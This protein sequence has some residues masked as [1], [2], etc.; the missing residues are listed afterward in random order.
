MPL[1][2]GVRF[3]RAGRV[4]YFDPANIELEVDDWV[5]VDTSRGK[6][7][8]RVVLAPKQVEEAELSEP[9]KPVLRKADASDFSKVQC[10]KEKIEAALDKCQERI[11]QHS[12]PMKLVGAE[13]SF[14]GSRLTFFFTSEGRVD[15]RDLVRDLASMFKT[16]IE[17]RQIGARDEARMIGGLGRCGRPLCCASFLT[18]FTNVSIKMA[19]EQDLPLNPQKISG[20]CGRLLCCLSYEEKQYCEIRAT[21]PRLDE[22]VT[23]SNGPGRVTAVNVVKESVMVEVESGSSVEVP[24]SQLAPRE[25]QEGAPTPARTR[26]RRP[27]KKKAAATTETPSSS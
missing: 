15:F 22:I 9:L 13:Y 5:V 3:K 16:R 27:R 21:L 8:G 17:L 7:V 10:N 1:V 25:P 24:V 12:L 23:T 20:L 2:V 18:D 11:N 14:D 26:R 4:Y 19:K 6:E